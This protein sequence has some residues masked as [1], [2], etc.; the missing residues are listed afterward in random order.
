M[1]PAACA[2]LSSRCADVESCCPSLCVGLQRW[3]CRA[4]LSS[5]TPAVRPTCLCPQAACV[6]QHMGTAAPSH[7]SIQA[8]HQAAAT[9]VGTGVRQLTGM[10]TI[11]I[12]GLQHPGAPS[13]GWCDLPAVR[14][15]TESSV[16]KP[17]WISA[18]LT[19]RRGGPCDSIWCRG[20]PTHS[21]AATNIIALTS[22]V[23]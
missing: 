19:I 23:R 15:A 6:A 13:A 18:L 2:W 8:A 1:R 5:L 9:R 14:K 16:R 17:T 20:C 10:L 21:C 22:P 11:A 12:L 3:L 4:P 7:S